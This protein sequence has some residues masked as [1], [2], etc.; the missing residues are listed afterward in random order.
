[1]VQTKKFQQ[2]I[3]VI[4]RNKVLLETDSPFNST[5]HMSQI[6]SLTWVNKTL[7]ELYFNSWSNFQQLVGR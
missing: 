2:M 1:M 7:D 4:P 3:D 6:E 5:P